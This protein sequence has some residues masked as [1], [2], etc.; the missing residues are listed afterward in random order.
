MVRPR[1][2]AALRLMINLNDSGLLHRQVARLRPLEDLSHIDGR[3]PEQVI[4]YIRGIGHRGPQPRHDP[5]VNR[6]RA[7]GT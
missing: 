1:A 2:L 4:G 7:A 6:P 5:G 3:A